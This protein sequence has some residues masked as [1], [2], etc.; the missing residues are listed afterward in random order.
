MDHLSRFPVSRPSLASDFELIGPLPR[1][2]KFILP[3]NRPECVDH[4]VFRGLDGTWHLWGCIR[5][6]A[7]GR[8]L[9]H[10][11]GERL[12]W[13]P[14]TPTGEFFRPDRT[15]G[16]SIADWEGQEWIQSP[17]I[18]QK[19]DLF[20]FFYGGHSTGMNLSGSEVPAGDPSVECQ[21][22][23]MTSKDGRSWK[24]YRN[25]LG[26]SRLFT[27]PGEAR[28]PCVLC[29]EGIWYMYYAGYESGNPLQP[30]I[31]L[32]NSTDLIHWSLPKL[33]HRT[34]QFG[35]G[36][37]THE[38]PHVIQRRDHFFLFRTEDYDRAITHIFWSDD[39]TDFGVDRIGKSQYLGMLP[40][41][42]PELIVDKHGDEYIT[43]C[44]DLQK[45]IKI[46]RLSWI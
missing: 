27:G 22:C 18:V 33:V 24:R 14:W 10:W 45:G 12:D 17:F 36:K 39:P 2:P 16:E 3:I 34:H 7:T 19:N 42:A 28:D 26:Q 25:E 15:A 23:L 1:I 6:T 31:Y 35:V 20:Y 8:I 46:C 30:G 32:R 40:L 38:C 21:I 29:I 5:G 43:S 44:H 37:W 13:G 9:Y 4:H 11:E 41:A